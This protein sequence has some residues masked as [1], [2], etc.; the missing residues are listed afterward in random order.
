MVGSSVLGSG[1]VDGGREDAEDGGVVGGLR[2]SDSV[3]ALVKSVWVSEMS[4][5]LVLEAAMVVQRLGGATR[6][7]MEDVK[8]RRLRTEGDTLK[9]C[10]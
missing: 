10:A 6:G 2:M 9:S 3:V 1:R 7:K 4:P 5:E 8:A